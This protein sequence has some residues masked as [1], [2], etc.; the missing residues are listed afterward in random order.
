MVMDQ[1]RATV[2]Y[3]PM[4]LERHNPRAVAFLIRESAP[5]LFALMFGPCAIRYLTE[6]VQ[7]SHNQFSYQYV[8]IAELDHKVVGLATLIPATCVNDAADYLDVLNLVQKLW[9]KLMQRFFLPSVLKLVYPVGSLYIGNL[10]VVAEYRNQG[11]GCQL[12]K[13]CITEA[14]VR[15]ST[16]FI[17]V[18]VSNGR[19][20][21]LYE[22]LGFQEVGKKIICLFGITLGS[23]ILSIT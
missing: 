4:S 13:H 3:V 17:S 16:I 10:A 15:S 11:I 1:Q 2:H 23:K 20:Q 22:S 9:L 14:T 5:E 6:L 7:R 12:L 21:K 8:H 19:A 18:S